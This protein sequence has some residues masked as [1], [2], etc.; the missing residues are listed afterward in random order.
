VPVIAHVD[1][2]AEIEEYG[3]DELTRMQLRNG[4]KARHNR[5]HNAAI[6]S[7]VEIRFRPGHSRSF[8]IPVKKAAAMSRGQ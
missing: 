4:E 6:A 7:V 2:A 1:A 5:L 3:A 8:A